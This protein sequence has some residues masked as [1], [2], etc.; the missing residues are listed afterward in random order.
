[1]DRVFYH[2]YHVGEGVSGFE[3][4]RAGRESADFFQ[5][6]YAVP[7]DHAGHCLSTNHKPDIQLRCGRF[8]PMAGR[9]ELDSDRFV[10]I[11]KLFCTFCLIKAYGF[12][13]VI[14]EQMLIVLGI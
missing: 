14:R 11:A 5:A 9:L 8:S 4:D 13:P 1:V 3:G 10:W 12:N 6:T 7:I 2:D